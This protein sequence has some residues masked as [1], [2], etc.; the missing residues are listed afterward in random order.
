M[1]ILV[2]H[3]VT[4]SVIDSSSVSP[5]GLVDHCSS[6]TA[7]VITK[8]R[9]T[10]IFSPGYPDPYIINAKCKWHIK[11]D[12]GYAIQLSFLEFDIEYG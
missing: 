2:R 9:N 5:N 8:A 3:Y 6:E 10:I 7:M 4:L 1:R 12:P 11:A